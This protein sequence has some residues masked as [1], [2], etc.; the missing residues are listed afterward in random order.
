M[1]ETN[2]YEDKNCYM[3]EIPLELDAEGKLANSVIFIANSEAEMED[4]IEF[5]LENEILPAV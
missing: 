1:S 5:L 4:K 2:F 3:V